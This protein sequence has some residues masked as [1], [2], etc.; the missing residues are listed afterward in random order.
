MIEGR[1]RIFN[2]TPCLVKTTV[3]FRKMEKRK[4]HASVIVLF[5]IAVALYLIGMTTPA[6]VFGAIGFLFELG[7]WIVWLSSDTESDST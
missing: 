4:I 7:A 3:R 6:V 1:L 5:A 2:E